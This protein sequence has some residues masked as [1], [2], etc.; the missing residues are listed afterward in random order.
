MSSGPTQNYDDETLGQWRPHPLVAA[1]VRVVLLALPPLAALVLGLTSARWASPAR[2]GIAPWLWLVLEI[3]LATAALLITATV[4]RR[5]L[6]LSTL[7]RLT[8]IF[9]D[10]A[11]SRFAVARRR[12][13]PDVLR[14]RVA[15]AIEPTEQEAHAAL[16][17]DL[18]AAIGAHD[19]V[20]AGHSERVQAYA[21]LIG[22]EL[23]LTAREAAKLG[24]AALLHDVGKITVPAEILTKPTRPTDAEWEVLSGHPAAGM[25]ITAPLSAWLGPWTDAVGQHHE[26]WDG[27]GYPLGLS[28]TEISRAARI[29]AVA[30]AFDAFTSTRSYKRSLSASAARAELARCSGEQFD[31][32][33]VRAFLAVGLGRLRRVAGPASLLAGLPGLGSTPLPSVASLVAAGATVGTTGVAVAVAGLIGAVLSLSGLATDVPTGASTADA[34]SSG[35]GA[36]V[37]PASGGAGTPFA[38]GSAPL[39][40]STAGSPSAGGAVPGRGVPGATASPT[41]SPLTAPAVPAAPS[42][43]PPARAPIP[44]SSVGTTQ[45]TST[46]CDQARAGSTSQVGADLSSCDL[47]GVTLTGDYS[48]VDLT[49]ADLT[50]AT[51]TRLDLSGA[52]LDGADLGGATIS[53][54]SFETAKL[55]GASFAGATVT[56]S[57]F[58]GTKLAPTTLKGAAVSDCSF[59]PGS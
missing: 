56:G 21:A 39:A 37:V 26:R 18:I 8:L 20:T 44:T 47:A 30:D 40:S 23:G 9:P 42:P 6:P 16:L 28:G 48:G 35:V 51:L 15:R 38:P 7:L 46:P 52:K 53:A 59:D 24:W 12:H 34:L 50:G 22:T 4:A 45:P 55:T 36:A 58:V 13:S 3:G 11:P 1:L 41:S 57:S 14:D 43:N 25:E 5:L 32:E 17:L 29:V 49:G 27:G 10:K 31:P 2:L 33:V 54:T 19:D